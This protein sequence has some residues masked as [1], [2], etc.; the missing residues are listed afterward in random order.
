[1]HSM[2]SHPSLGKESVTANYQ[3]IPER[4]LLSE[5]ADLDGSILKATQFRGLIYRRNGQCSHMFW[6]DINEAEDGAEGRD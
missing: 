5:E 4:K 3:L 1:M 6:A 2:N